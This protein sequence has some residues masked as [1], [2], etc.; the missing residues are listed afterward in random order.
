MALGV[1]VNFEVPRSRTAPLGRAATRTLLRRAARAALR[2]E[3]VAHAEVTITLLDDAA[4]TALNKRYLAHDYPTDV[5]SFPL[6][7]EGDP[8]LGDIYIGWD[9]ALRQA[10]ALGEAPVVEI[11]RLAIHGTLHIL[12]YDHP[13]GTGRERS[14]MWKRQEE[15][16]QKVAGIQE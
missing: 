13:E 8:P 15:I 4:I 14:S 16:L 5:I 6:H 9:Q 2:A 12:G 10:N 11:A 7:H 1:V 3:G